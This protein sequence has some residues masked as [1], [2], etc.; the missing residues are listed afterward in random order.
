MNVLLLVPERHTR[1]T[2]EVVLAQRGYRV[3]VHDTPA[4]AEHALRQT[5]YRLLFCEITN[6]TRSD[7]NRLTSLLKQART[8]ECV[9]VGIM[10]DQGG[11]AQDPDRIVEDVVHHIVRTPLDAPSVRRLLDEIEHQLLRA[12]ATSY[13]LASR[14]ATPDEIDALLRSDAELDL[15]LDTEHRVRYVRP[16]IEAATGYRPAELI[17]RDFTD[18][19]DPADLDLLREAFARIL[20]TDIRLRHPERGLSRWRIRIIER[21]DNGQTRGHRVV[22]TRLHDRE[23]EPLPQTQ[24][25]PIALDEHF[26]ELELLVLTLD[27]ELRVRHWPRYT[28]RRL[29]RGAEEVTGRFIGD[30]DILPLDE[31]ERALHSGATNFRFAKT[32]A[33]PTHGE[34][35][36]RWHGSVRRIDGEIESILLVGVDNSDHEAGEAA[37][38]R[39]EQRF[40]ALVEYSADLIFVFDAEGQILYV[41]PSVERLFHG[42]QDFSFEGERLGR[43]HPDDRE[44]AEELFANVIE[45]P[46]AIVRAEVRMRIGDSDE[47]RTFEVTARNLLQDLNVEGVVVNAHDITE[48]REAQADLQRSEQRFR[49]LVQNSNDILAIL[50]EQATVQF[51]SP[52]VESIL[53][54]TTHE[55]KGRRL[56]EFVH[57]D[58]AE[59]FSDSLQRLSAAAGESSQTEIRLRHREGNWR[60]VEA[61]CTNLFDEPGI[62]GIVMNAHDITERKQLERGLTRRAFLDPLTGLPNRSLFLHRLARTL[63]EIQ[64]QE[65]PVAVLFLDIDRFKVVN[66]SLGHEIGDQLLIAIGRRLQGLVRP[67]DTVARFGGDEMI[68][69]LAGI[70]DASE[71]AL[72]A[73]R[74]IE[75]LGKPMQLEQHEVSVAASVGIAVSTT[76]QEDAN[77]L[78]RNAD[79]AL[80]RAKESGSGRY[81]VF[82]ESMASRVRERLTLESELRKAIE[83]GQFR[84]E[85]LPEIDLANGNL[86]GLEVL[87]RW[88]HPERGE[89]PPDEFMLVAN[90][91]GL[92]VPMG[93]LVLNQACAQLRRWHL[94]HPAAQGLFLAVNMSAREFQQPDAVD[95]LLRTLNQHSLRPEQLRLEVDE[96]VIAADPSAAFDK[97]HRLRRHGI[98]LAIDDFGTGYSSLGY[99]TRVTFDTLKIARHFISGPGG[100]TNNLS[101]VRAVTSL[102]HALGM[103]VT[104][105]GIE[106]REHLTR[107][108]AAGCDFG[109]G[110]LFSEPLEAHAVESLLFT[111]NNTTSGGSNG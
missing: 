47:W 78:I 28:A 21:G 70:T 79:I 53:G 30:L 12:D 5:Q 31:L 17:G 87:V 66:D 72:I 102:A 49:T 42:E 41:S 14:V 100:I 37:L 107:V 4:D 69:L 63:K 8:Q 68:I 25:E 6:S 23:P 95:A 61:H 86:V 3:S 20:T 40:R 11:L 106:T 96:A 43:L 92:V 29:E 110:Y 80:Y 18:F 81:V 2:L 10:Q 59:Q 88:Q 83:H 74:I 1:S 89:I 77:D 48:Q 33:R 105:E 45:T 103:S 65:R 67:A 36:V 97:L 99:L 82:D 9:V 62:A 24:A 56:T 13:D 19:V 94:H 7:D 26:E 73:Q 44:K 27:S 84:Y 104:A 64:T 46:G 34:V 35:W 85:Y 91:T 75:Q 38:R 93:R 71:A 16:G 50:D 108:R 60:V 76:G 32:I 58:E 109:Q 39:S 51:I 101:I 111:G 57:E 54:Y 90:E 22:G 52:S 55:L 15:I 98:R